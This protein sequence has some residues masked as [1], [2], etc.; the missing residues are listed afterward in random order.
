MNPLFKIKMGPVSAVHRAHY[1]NTKG[2][3]EI[4]ELQEFLL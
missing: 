4:Q 1:R 2:Y 3:L